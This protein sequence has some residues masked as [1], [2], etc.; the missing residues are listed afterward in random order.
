MERHAVPA[1]RFRALAAPT[2]RALPVRLSLSA[3]PFRRTLS[4]ARLAY[5]AGQRRSLA[6][7][8]EVYSARHGAGEAPKRRSPAHPSLPPPASRACFGRKRPASQA[9]PPSGVLVRPHNA[10]RAGAEA[11]T[12]LQKGAPR[13]RRHSPPQPPDLALAGTV[14]SRERVPRAAFVGRPRS[15]AGS[16]PKGRTHRLI[17]GFGALSPHYVLG[18]REFSQR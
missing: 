13:R 6:E 17:K 5:R 12:R 7:S 16:G 18:V 14:R 8:T 9:R 2:L 10:T 15:A 1:R 3:A 4:Q 11:R